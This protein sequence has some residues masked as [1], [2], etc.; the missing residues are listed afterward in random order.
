MD[1]FTRC[2]FLRGDDAWPRRAVPA[3]G[4]RHTVMD[5]RVRN[6]TRSSGVATVMRL[7]PSIQPPV[8]V[9]IRCLAA[10]MRAAPG[11]AVDRRSS[12]AAVPPGRRGR[13]LRGRQGRSG[14]GGRTG[15][16]TGGRARVHCEQVPPWCC[17]D[18]TPAD[19]PVLVELWADVLRRV[20]PEEQDADLRHVHRAAGLRRW[21]GSWSRSTTASVAGAVLLRAT[22]ATPLNLEPLVQAL[23]PHVLPAY[24]RRGVGRALME[25][26]VAFAEEHGIG[27]VALRRPVSVLARRQP[28]PGPARARPAGDAPGSAPTATVRS[29]LD[30]LRAR[31]GPSGAPDRPRCSPPAARCGTATPRRPRRAE[32]GP[33]SPARAPRLSRA[34]R[35]SRRSRRDQQAGD[36]RGADPLAALVGDHDL[37]GRAGAAEVDRGRHAGDGPGASP[38]GGGWR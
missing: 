25:A 20:D 1:R 6:D 33:A 9:V 31:P 3:P 28:L 36:P 27:H 8:T 11:G 26:R 15:L 18:A 32:Q 29:R 19:A 13:R 37:V 38:R 17:V 22:T 34:S 21:S 5:T 23:S 10:L 12:G 24:R 14:G 4:L 30:A 2:T 35:L 16:P 7:M